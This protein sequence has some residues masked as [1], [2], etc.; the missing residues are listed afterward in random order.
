MLSAG[1]ENA[2]HRRT[3][4]VALLITAISLLALV[5]RLRGVYREFWLDELVTAWVVRDG[6]GPLF[7]RPG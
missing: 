2:A 7:Q 1:P 5:V 4:L 3:V 6:F